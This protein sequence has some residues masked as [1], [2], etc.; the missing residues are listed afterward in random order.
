MK[1]QSSDTEYSPYD[2]PDDCCE[3]R[4]EE[5]YLQFRIETVRERKVGYSILFVFKRSFYGVN[6]DRTR[7]ESQRRS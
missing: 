4:D 6:W 5:L 1:S 7:V 2:G 3:R